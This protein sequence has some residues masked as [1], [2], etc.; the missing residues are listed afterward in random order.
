MFFNY[1]TG[2]S[3]LNQTAHPRQKDKHVFKSRHLFSFIDF[4]QSDASSVKCDI[5]QKSRF[6]LPHKKLL[7]QT[8]LFIVFIF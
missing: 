5:Y 7:A 4:D 3:E 1:G 6:Y 8:F 2:F